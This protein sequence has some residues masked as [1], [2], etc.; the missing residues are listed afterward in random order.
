MSDFRTR[1]DEHQVVLLG[2][3]LSLLCCNF[4]LVVQICLVAHEDYDYVVASFSSDIIDPFSCLLE[5]FGVCDM[6]RPGGFVTY[7]EV[8]DCLY[9][10]RLLLHSSRGCMKVSDFEI[11]LGLLCPRAVIVLC[12]LR[13][14][15]SADVVSMLAPLRPAPRATHL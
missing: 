5:G 14:T 9:R 15:L 6:I 2:F 7:G 12:G 4:S 1:L 3:F 10:R 13:G 8:T 11:A